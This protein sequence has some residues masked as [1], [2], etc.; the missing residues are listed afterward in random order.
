MA[1]KATKQAD[2]DLLQVIACGATVESAARKAGVSE[3]TAYRRLEDAEFKRHLTRL[4]HSMVERSAAMLTAAGMESAKTLLSLQNA[5]IPASVRLGAARAV[6]EFGTK[7]R[8][9]YELEERIVR[10]EERLKMTS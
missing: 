10:L 3:R 7:L 5:S 4:R 1:R 6:L 9:A 2:H 8:E